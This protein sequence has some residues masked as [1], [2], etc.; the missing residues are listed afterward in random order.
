[1]VCGGGLGLE[2]GEEEE[3]AFCD[4]SGRSFRCIVI[5]NLRRRSSSWYATCVVKRFGGCEYL[6]ILGTLYENYNVLVSSFH[7]FR[8]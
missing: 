2:E 8:C 4:F 6:G 1:V 7:G 5:W 3:A